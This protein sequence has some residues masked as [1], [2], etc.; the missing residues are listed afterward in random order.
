MH[1]TDVASISVASRLVQRSTARPA[2]AETSCWRTW[3]DSCHAPKSLCENELERGSR[4]AALRHRSHASTQQ[5]WISL[6]HSR[7]PSRNTPTSIKCIPHFKELRSK[8]KIQTSAF[9]IWPLVLIRSLVLELRFVPPQCSLW[10][11]RGANRDAVSKSR[12]GIRSHNSDWPSC[13]SSRQMNSEQRTQKP[14][15]SSAFSVL[16]SAFCVHRDHDAGQFGQAMNAR[17]G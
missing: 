9:D 16:C 15:E 10:L 2:G 12:M 17:P 5:R 6:Q 4:T 3:P 8:A 14:P 1:L 13:Q 11:L 7:K